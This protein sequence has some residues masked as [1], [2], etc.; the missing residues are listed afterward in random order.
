MASPSSPGRSPT[1]FYLVDDTEQPQ[2]E[3]QQAIIDA[4]AK[5]TH[6]A[7]ADQNGEIIGSTV[8]SPG[9]IRYPSGRSACAPASPARF[10][11]TTEVYPF[12]S[13]SAIGRSNAMRRRRRRCVFGHRLA[14]GCCAPTPGS[15]VGGDG[16]GPGSLPLKPEHLR[17]QMPRFVACG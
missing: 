16:S 1:A 7:P 9:V 5:V 6:I 17:G 12:D 8:V 10:K 2:P 15:G 4:V 13:P 14:L 3:F 11:A